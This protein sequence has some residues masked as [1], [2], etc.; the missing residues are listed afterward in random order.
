MQFNTEELEAIKDALIT[1][2]RYS[3]EI[4]N[5]DLVIRILDRIDEEANLD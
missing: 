5:V 3:G 2:L 1:S 4:E